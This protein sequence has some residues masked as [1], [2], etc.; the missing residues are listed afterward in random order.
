MAWM[1]S[2]IYSEQILDLEMFQRLKQEQPLNEILVE[3]REIN[4]IHLKL[5]KRK[6]NY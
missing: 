6:P 4:F 1:Q 2:R 5:S 3:K